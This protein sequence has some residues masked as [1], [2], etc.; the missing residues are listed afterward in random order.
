MLLYAGGD[1]TA[2]DV[3]LLERAAEAAAR[4]AHGRMDVYL[5]A[6][7]SADVA[8][9]VLPLVRDAAGEFAR[10]YSAPG[11]S[12]YVLRPDGYLG[13]AVRI[14]IWTVWCGICGRLPLAATRRFCS[15]SKASGYLAGM[16][17]FTPSLDWGNELWTS[18]VWI[19]WAWAIAAVCTLVILV[20]IARYTDWGRQFW[21]ITG[22]YFTG[23]PSVKVW[24][25]LAVLLLFVI[26]GVRLDVLFSYQGNDMLTAS[27]WL[28]RDISA[29]D[30]AVRK[31]L[32]GTAF[33]CP[34]SSSASWRPCTS[35]ASCWT[36]S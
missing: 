8:T 16:E 7:P 36:C 13:F 14:S 23:P 21:R 24:L 26:A 22:A 9:T 25:W 5:I 20:L 28:P 30:E 2:D 18:L 10:M 3:A 31:T 29:G 6:A 27:R 1:A 32:A 33:G 34:W 35:R 11:P 12:V 4:A 17:T 19:A 15:G